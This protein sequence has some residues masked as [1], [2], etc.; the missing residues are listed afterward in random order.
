MI[1]RIASRTNS[2]MPSLLARCSYNGEEAA[3]VARAAV[4][5][6]LDGDRRAGR[7]GRMIAAR[8]VR[9]EAELQPLPAYVLRDGPRHGV[10]L[11]RAR[12]MHGDGPFLEDT[13][14]PV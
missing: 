3:T 11:R 6:L 4:L 2:N 12:C 10:R 7:N 13:V 1:A 9:R 5:E 8:V 14:P